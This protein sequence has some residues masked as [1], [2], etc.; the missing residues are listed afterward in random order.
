M[1]DYLPEN[2]DA[3]LEQGRPLEPRRGGFP[4]L[5]ALSFADNATHHQ[6]GES[7]HAHGERDEQDQCPGE[8]LRGWEDGIV[9][10]GR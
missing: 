5:P 1:N 3:A 7:G 10:L 2:G 9:A 8:E 4:V 6:Q